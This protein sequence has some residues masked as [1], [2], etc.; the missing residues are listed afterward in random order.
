VAGFLELSAGAD[1]LAHTARRAGQLGEQMATLA[2]AAVGAINAHDTSAAFGHDKFAEAF[3]SGPGGYL[4]SN[5]PVK[6]A[7]VRLGPAVA[8]LADKVANFAAAVGDTDSAAAQ[9]ITSAGAGASP[10]ASNAPVRDAAVMR[11]SVTTTE[12]PVQR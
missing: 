1:A 4:A 3:T 11:M 12:E 5:E 8:S 6:R 7:V 9:S 2:E 10:T